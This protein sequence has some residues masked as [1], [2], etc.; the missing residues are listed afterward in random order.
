MNNYETNPRG[1]GVFPQCTVGPPISCDAVPFRFVVNGD[2]R[3]W[4]ILRVIMKNSYGAPG[5]GPSVPAMALAAQDMARVTLPDFAPFLYCTGGVVAC[6]PAVVDTTQHTWIKQPT[7]VTVGL[8]AFRSHYS[9]PSIAG[10]SFD[11]GAPA[12]VV[13]GTNQSVISGY[14]PWSENGGDMAG[15][16]FPV[17]VDIDALADTGTE[18]VRYLQ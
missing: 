18:L 10:V 11:S 4:T 12:T 6:T 5:V 16:I 1:A 14:Q 13:D 3:A 7:G 8:Q 2:Y 17:Q 15:A 9:I